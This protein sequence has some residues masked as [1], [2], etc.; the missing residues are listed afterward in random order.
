MSMIRVLSMYWL[1][2][3][4]STLSLYANRQQCLDECAAEN[5]T[6]VTSY[7]EQCSQQ[8]CTPGLYTCLEDA[9]YT[10]NYCYV[11]C[12]YGGGQQSCYDNCDTN[13]SN[14]IGAC[15]GTYYTCYGQCTAIGVEG[16]APSYAECV[17]GCPPE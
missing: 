5:N 14:S 3:C 7:A 11:Q 16:C 10:R 6:C 15:Y 4:L 8:T 17:A 13:Y 2:L 12:L 9:Q 1:V